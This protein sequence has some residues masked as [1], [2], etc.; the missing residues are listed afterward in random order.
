MR[1]L[2]QYLAIV[3]MAVASV[4]VRV[5]HLLALVLDVERRERALARQARL[6]AEARAAAE[7]AEW[8]ARA[9]AAI[10]LADRYAA[11]A[12]ASRAKDWLLAVASHELRS[13]LQA[14]LHWLRVLRRDGADAATIARALDGIEQSTKWQC[15]LVN[16]LL[17]VSRIWSGTLR[18][19]PQQTDPA[20]AVQAAIELVR[21]AAEQK[22]VRVQA[23]SEPGIGPI[24]ADPTRLEQIAVNLLSNAVRFTPPGGGVSVRLRQATDR[25]ELVVSDTGQGIPAE[26]LPHVFDAFR[27]ATPSVSRNGGLGLGL[28]IVRHLVACHGGTVEASSPGPGQGAAFTVRLPV[29]PRG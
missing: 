27:Q 10:E 29:A 16:D 18:L 3:A 26:I 5:V 9:S 22:G 21:P 8:R 28:A 12:E 13:P 25:V 4:A 19:A 2:L 23:A 11:A 24:I 1:R 17:D 20:S 6:L 15:Q 14:T 7:A